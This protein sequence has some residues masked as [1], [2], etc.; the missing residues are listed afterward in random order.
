MRRRVDVRWRLRASDLPTL[1]RV[2]LDLLQRA[3][4]RLKPDGVLVYSTCSL[5]AEENE[6]VIA[7][8]LKKRADFKQETARAITPMADDVDGAFV[9]RL[10]KVSASA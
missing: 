8:F 4:A 3:A 6:D 10:R 1:A 7:A 2:Q 5:E 9:A